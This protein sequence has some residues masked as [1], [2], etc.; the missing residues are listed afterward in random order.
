MRDV[1]IRLPRCARPSL[2]LKLGLLSCSS[3]RLV[4]KK[5]KK[6]RHDDHI[7]TSF[8]FLL[9]L[10][11]VFLLFLFFF[12]PG[13]E[14]DVPCARILRRLPGRHAPQAQHGQPGQEL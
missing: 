1:T 8:F 14:R 11:F 3:I 6:V 13:A 2:A 10:F 9:L 5:G 4:Q 7:L 12:S